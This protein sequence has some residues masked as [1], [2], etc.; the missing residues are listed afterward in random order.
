[1]ANEKAAATPAQ[2]ETAAAPRTA[3]RAQVLAN[4]IKAVEDAGNMT[5]KM[6]RNFDRMAARIQRRK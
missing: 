1:M 4:M 5:P 2:K 3:S 6:Q